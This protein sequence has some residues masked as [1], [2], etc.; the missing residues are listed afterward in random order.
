MNRVIH[1]IRLKGKEIYLE[2]APYYGEISN[3]EWNVEVVEELIKFEVCPKNTCNFLLG[4]INDP[5]IAL[6]GMPEVSTI[7]GELKMNRVDGGW[8]GI[9]YQFINGEN[10]YEVDENFTETKD[11]VD[12][13]YE[14]YYVR[15][16]ASKK[17]IG[18]WFYFNVS[19]NSLLQY[20]GWSINGAK[21]IRAG[22]GGDIK[23]SG[24]ISLEVCFYER[25]GYNPRILQR[26]LKK[27]GK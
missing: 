3:T 23:A 18:A 25:A 2:I 21:L 26:K 1:P 11:W 4:Y 13:P 7:E 12:M 14:H 5:F 16:R 15:T 8:M 9:I 22:L 6:Y 24:Y 10:Y 17:P 20:V 27:E 19:L